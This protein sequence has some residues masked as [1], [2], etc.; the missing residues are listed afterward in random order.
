MST[1]WDLILIKVEELRE[2]S[3]M[4]TEEEEIYAL[5]IAIYNLSIEVARKV[6]ENGDKKKE[7]EEG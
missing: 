2:F 6:K 3:E 4:L 5:Y 1:L 7:N